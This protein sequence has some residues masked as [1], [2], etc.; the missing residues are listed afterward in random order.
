MWVCVQAGMGQGSCDKHQHHKDSAEL[1][2]AWWGVTV[3]AMRTLK[4]ES[5]WCGTAGVSTWGWCQG[6]TGR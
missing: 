3:L 1:R 5:W 4:K 6:Q 2:G